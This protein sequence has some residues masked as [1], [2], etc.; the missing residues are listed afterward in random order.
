MWLLLLYLYFKRRK[1]NIIMSDITFEQQ[2]KQQVDL[3]LLR[4]NKTYFTLVIV[5]ISLMACKINY[6][7]RLVLQNVNDLLLIKFL[8]QMIIISSSGF[9]KQSHTLSQ[10]LNLLMIHHLENSLLKIVWQWVQSLTLSWSSK[11]PQWRCGLINETTKFYWKIRDCSKIFKINNCIYDNFLL[12]SVNSLLFLV[13]MEFYWW[14]V[15]YFDG[16]WFCRYELMPWVIWTPFELDINC[17]GWVWRKKRANDGLSTGI[18]FLFFSF[19][20]YHT[21]CP[22]LQGVSH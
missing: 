4:C 12:E 2:N 10:A 6:A 20:V 15:E 22:K 7:L 18:I 14:I 17:C 1:C 3:L 5:F 19:Q 11:F 9:N 13:S 16:R 21:L 8:L